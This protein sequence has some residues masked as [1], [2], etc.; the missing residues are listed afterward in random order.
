MKI[1]NKAQPVNDKFPY[2]QPD[3]LQRQPRANVREFNYNFEQFR[4]YTSMYEEAR[5]KDEQTSKDFYKLVKYVKLK[6]DEKGQPIDK[7]NL[8]VRDFLKKYQ[9]DLI[10]IPQEFQNLPSEDVE[11]RVAQN[12]KA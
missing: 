5:K 1:Q 12:R 6:V 4:E 10:Q 11:Q 9:L 3:Y 8:I 2:E 7:S